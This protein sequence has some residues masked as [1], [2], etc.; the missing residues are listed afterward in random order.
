MDV[1]KARNTR[2][3]NVIG[4]YIGFVDSDD[5]FEPDIYEIMYNHLEKE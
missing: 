5:F 2:L 4:E 1:S 3:K